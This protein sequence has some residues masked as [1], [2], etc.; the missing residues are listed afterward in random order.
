MITGRAAKLLAKAKK[1]G[2]MTGAV[3]SLAAVNGR[4][5]ST[6]RCDNVSQR[7]D[8]LPHVKSMINNH[9]DALIRARNDPQ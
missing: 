4:A 2:L 8:V 9:D 7:A 6:H 3:A 5:T 1:D